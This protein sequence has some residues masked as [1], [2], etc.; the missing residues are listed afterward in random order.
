LNTVDRPGINPMWAKTVKSDYS[1]S[2]LKLDA[3]NYERALVVLEYYVQHRELPPDF[4]P[5]LGTSSL[6]GEG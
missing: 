4:P 1:P 6:T 2:Q 3:E 5:P